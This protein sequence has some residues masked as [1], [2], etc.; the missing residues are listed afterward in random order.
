M[1][2]NEYGYIRQRMP[3]EPSVEDETGQTAQLAMV[4]APDQ[5]FRLIYTPADALTRGTLFEELDKP[6][7][8]GGRCHGKE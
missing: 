2:K 7:E 3:A 6:L 1:E 4:Y 8:N 5:M